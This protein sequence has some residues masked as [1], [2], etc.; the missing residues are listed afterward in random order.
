MRQ[1]SSHRLLA[2]A[3]AVCLAGPAASQIA[4]PPDAGAAAPPGAVDIIDLDPAYPPRMTVSVRIGGNGPFPFIVDTGAARTVISNNLAGQL[5]LEPGKP[6]RLHSMTGVGDVATAIIPQLELSRRRVSGIHAPVLRETFIGASGI[7]GVDTLRSQR[8][9]FDFA[10]Q[11]MSIEPSPA[12]T[13]RRDTEAI[14]V[15]ARS[16]FGRLVLVDA[17]LEGEKVVVVLDTG[18]EVTVGNE[19]LRRKL[20]RKRKLKPTRPIELISV[21]GGRITADYTQMERMR[22]G[23]ITISQMPIAFARVHPFTQL[24]LDDR[25]AMLLGMDTLKL[26]SRVSVDFAKKKVSFLLPDKPARQQM[27]AAREAEI[28][29]TLR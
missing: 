14:V 9:E 24:Q 27:L 2:L 21:T 26:F 18:S 23:N 6:V 16:L 17:D 22:L 5:A 15:T 8:V 28:P 13:L 7:L 11:K 29:V 20:E 3:L 1:G 25:P 4:P 10:R 19:A 12:V